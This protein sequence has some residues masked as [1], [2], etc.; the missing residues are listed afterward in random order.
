M[1]SRIRDVNGL[2]DGICYVATATVGNRS[3]TYV[4]KTLNT[5]A[6]RYPNGPEGGLGVVFDR[7]AENGTEA[8]AIA[9]YNVSN[10]ALV[11]GWCYQVAT[12]RAK[13]PTYILTNIQDPS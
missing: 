3:W 13:L 8:L 9:L 5:M 10:P 2:N 1:W 4:G 11:E 12:D 6:A 7:Y